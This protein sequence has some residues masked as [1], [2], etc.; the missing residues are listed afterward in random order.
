MQHNLLLD[1]LCSNVKEIYKQKEYI[2]VNDILTEKDKEILEKEASEE[3]PFDKL[4]LKKD[5]YNKFLNKKATPIVKKTEHARIVILCESESIDEFYP[6]NTWGRMFQWLG[7]PKDSNIWQIYIYASHVKRILPTQGPIDA[8][9]LNGGYTYPCKADCI[10]VYRYEEATRV[11]IHELLHASCTD[12]F[13]KPVEQREA[14]TELWAEL[15][16]VALLSKGNQKLA[17]KLWRIQDHYI[18]DL[19]STVYNY[20]HTKKPEDYGARYTILRTPVLYDLGFSHDKKYT[21]KKISIS[22]FTS[23]DLDKYLV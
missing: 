8:S 6:W 19:N 13:S 11:M 18:Q 15:F 10:V 4:N 2:W 3:S 14:S 5:M 20:H 16:L 7:M 12:D 22:R 9:H 17:E 1:M 23:P 21:P